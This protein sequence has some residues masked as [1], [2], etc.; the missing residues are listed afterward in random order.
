MFNFDI[1]KCIQKIHTEMYKEKYI[2]STF[3]YYAITNN[4]FVKL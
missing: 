2:S 1:E 4:P 3:L